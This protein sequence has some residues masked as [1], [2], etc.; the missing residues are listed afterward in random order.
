MASTQ[1]EGGPE[2]QQTAA[3]QFSVLKIAPTSFFSDYGCHVRI[4]EESLALQAL[5][6]QVTI[7]T[8]HTG[9]D[10]K[11]LSIHRAMNTPWH[12]AVQVGSNIHKLYYDVL[13][14]LEAARTALGLRPQIVHAH[15]HEG[16]LIGYLISRALRAPLIF[17]FQGSLTSEML[18]H[19]FLHR[20]SPFFRPLRL[21]E[22]I[23]NRLPEAIVTSSKNAADILVRDFAYPANRVYTVPD[24]VN[25]ERFRPRWQVPDQEGIREMKAQLGIPQDR[26]V[27]VYL[28]LLAEYQ[29]IGTLL[30]AAAYLIQQRKLPVHFL[31]MG[32]PG[33]ERYRFRAAQLG[34]SQWVTFTGR[35]PYLQA[36]DYLLIGDVAVSPKISETEGNGKL[37]NYMAAGLPT[38]TFNTPVAR[39]ILGD[40]G[41]YAKQG[42]PKSLARAL[43]FLLL[44]ERA[45]SE[46]ALRLRLKAVRDHSWEKA[47]KQITEIY[48]RF[49]G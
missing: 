18:D 45:A 6:N 7:C 23:V 29:G 8:Y 4:Y 25:A 22:R 14:F 40:L 49:A 38:A 32:F 39:E 16:A 28:G 34:L 20:D 26:K 36:P 11:G 24:C 43:E 12:N 27:V 10:V 33:E 48:Q 30:E 3:M 46:I 13:L 19:N 5:G 31:I 15:L 17:D 2:A 21:L 9:D 41:V 1:Q 44:E 42:D 37:L 35:I 47:G